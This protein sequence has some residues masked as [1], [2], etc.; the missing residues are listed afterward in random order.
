MKDSLLTETEII[1]LTGAKQPKKQREVLN[2]SGI[3]FVDRADNGISL[4][5]GHVNNPTATSRLQ[6]DEQPNFGAIQ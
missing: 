4:T 5:W 6:F 3:F 2:R 1:A